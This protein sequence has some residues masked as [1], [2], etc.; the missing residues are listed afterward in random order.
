MILNITQKEHIPAIHSNCINQTASECS[1]KITT[2]SQLVYSE[3]DMLDVSLYST[4]ASEI[5]TKMISR[6]S[7]LLA[8]TGKVVS[9]NETDSGNVCADINQAVI[10][11][12][13]FIAPDKVKARYMKNGT[14]LRVGDDIG[15]LNAGP[16]WIWTPLVIT[17]ICSLF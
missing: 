3:F 8:K 6:Q 14:Q 15:P 4:A 1:L 13:L 9:F 5:R 17:Y 10:D 7:V 2:V 11:Y 12:A 16:L